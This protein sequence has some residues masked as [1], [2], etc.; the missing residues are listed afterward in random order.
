MNKEDVK[1][2][3]HELEASCPL[4]IHL[5]VASSSIIFNFPDHFDCIN[6][7]LFDIPVI[8]EE[9]VQKRLN[10]LHEYAIKGHRVWAEN[11]D[12]VFQDNEYEIRKIMEGR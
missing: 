12:G 9:G 1:K 10:F 8:I 11:A 7:R 6:S 2:V 5:W 4:P 3:T